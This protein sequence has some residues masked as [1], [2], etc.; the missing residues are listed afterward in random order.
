MVCL[1][2]CLPCTLDWINLNNDCWE[3]SEKSLFH[4]FP[5]TIPLWCLQLH[6]ELCLLCTHVQNISISKI[7]RFF[8]YS[9]N[10]R[11]ISIGKG[12]LSLSLP[13]RVRRWATVKTCQN[14]NAIW[15][16]CVAGFVFAFPAWFLGPQLRCK[17][18]CKERKRKRKAEKE[19]QER[20]RKGRGKIGKEEER[21]RKGR[22]KEEERKR[23][24][25]GKEEERK[26]KGRGKEE[27]RNGG[28][29]YG[30]VEV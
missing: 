28:K 1:S 16:I 4:S 19:K 25:R 10:R 9:G 18:L 17:D 3:M 30:M 13:P 29:G 5:S 14:S 12:T 7:R 26:R 23:K 27:E 2:W 11:R 21:K 6:R 22:G 24:G 8:S 15:W 20:K